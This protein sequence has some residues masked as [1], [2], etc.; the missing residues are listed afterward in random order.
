VRLRIDNETKRGI[1]VKAPRKG[2]VLL[3]TYEGVFRPGN[4]VVGT[5]LLRQQPDGAYVEVIGQRPV[6]VE[7]WPDDDSGPP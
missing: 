6:H 1:V 4:G 5:L 7:L 2:R 3:V